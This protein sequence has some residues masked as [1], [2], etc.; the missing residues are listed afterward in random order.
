MEATGVSALVCGEEPNRKVTNKRTRTIKLMR[1]EDS[2]N[3][4]RTDHVL[5]IRS[6]GGTD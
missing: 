3:S 1:F 2:I 4:R 5:A 6:S